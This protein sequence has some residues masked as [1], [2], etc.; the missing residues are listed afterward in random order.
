M[1]NPS[2]SNAYYYNG[3]FY[4][5]LKNYQLA[6]TNVTKSIE[7]KTGFVS[8]YTYKGYYEYLLGQKDKACVDFHKGKE[9]GDSKADFYIGK[10]CK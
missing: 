9:L 2:Y 6:L 7:L 5:E 4:G 8:A 10:Y 1:L 3:C